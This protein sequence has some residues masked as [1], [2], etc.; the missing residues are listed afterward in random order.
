MTHNDFM[1][2]YNAIPCNASWVLR[3]MIDPEHKR[4]EAV[5]GVMIIDGK[6]YP[7]IL[8]ADASR[9]DLRFFKMLP[10]K[11]ANGIIDFDIIDKAYKRE[12]FEFIE[13]DMTQEIF[14]KCVEEIMNAG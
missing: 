7:G 3:E 8:L 13:E 5:A 2:K 14:D 9:E 12:E 11:D 1:K 4:P 10:Y 6:R